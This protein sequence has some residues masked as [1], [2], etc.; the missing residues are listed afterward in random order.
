[1]AASVV[2]DLAPVAGFGRLT[3]QCQG[4]KRGNGAVAC[5]AVVGVSG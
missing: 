5:C 2:Q 3:D 1:L 4:L